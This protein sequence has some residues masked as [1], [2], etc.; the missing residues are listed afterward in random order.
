MTDKK[1]IGAVPNMLGKL[2]KHNLD[3]AA[4]YSL[5]FQAEA[6][7]RI[8]T[9]QIHR[10]ALDTLLQDL[11]ELRSKNRGARFIIF[12]STRYW[13]IIGSSRIHTEEIDKHGTLLGCK[14]MIFEDAPTFDLK[15][16][17]RDEGYYIH[18][19]KPR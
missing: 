7:Q 4:K 17:T 12:V 5:D 19:V 13:G 1:T 2:S 15:T 8:Y 16:Q 3:V 11:M 10:N 18:C 14:L 6:S 9:Q